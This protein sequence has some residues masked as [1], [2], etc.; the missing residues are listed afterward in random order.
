LE[1]ALSEAR[2]AEEALVQQSSPQAIGQMG[3]GKV[4]HG[5][6]VH[7]AGRLPQIWEDP[8]TTDAQRKALLRCLVDKVVLDRGEHDVA[9][10]RIVW[11][12]GAVTNLEVKVRVNSVLKLNGLPDDEIAATLTGEGHRSPNC[13]NMV[14]PIT[15]GQIRRG[16]GI[17]VTEPRTRW[18]HETGLL[19]APQLAVRLNIPVNWIYVQI[20]EKRL[21]I[22]RQPTGAYLFQDTTPVLDAVRNLRNHTINRL[23]LRICKPHKEGHQHA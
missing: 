11:R 15:V 12:G 16:A 10:V 9:Q 14:L 22:D 23:D 8:A 7:L 3:V 4:L 2:A 18:S 21:L 19:S 1:E 20:R 5:K 13:E 6:V 17:R